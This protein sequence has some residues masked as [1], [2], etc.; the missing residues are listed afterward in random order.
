M[1]LTAPGWM[2]AVLGMLVA[3]L[4]G[5]RLLSPAG[6]MPSFEGGAITI[7]SCP[8]ADP[9]AAPSGHH[10]HGKSSKIRQPCTYAAASA[11]GLTLFDGVMLAGIVLIGC[12]TLLGRTYRLIESSR[13]FRRPPS[14]GPP[15]PV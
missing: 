8:D 14:R 12:A 7:V 1:R 9:E 2:R 3:L 4:M 10:G 15:L 6:F 11:S 13:R 5:V